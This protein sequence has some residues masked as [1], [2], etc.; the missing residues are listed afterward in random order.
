M[1]ALTGDTTG[2]CYTWSGDKKIY[3]SDLFSAAV[4]IFSTE[5]CYRYDSRDS[6]TLV[7]NSPDD[8]KDGSLSYLPCG[9]L[10]INHNIQ[11]NGE[12]HY[13]LSGT[14][15]KPEIWSPPAGMD[16]PFDKPHGLK[17]PF[18]I[19]SIVCTG[20]VYTW[21]YDHICVL[22]VDNFPYTQIHYYGNKE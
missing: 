19:H 7:F 5:W 3:E 4:N 6:Y 22:D 2:T 1:S 11:D 21:Y 16:G 14:Y 20:H 12:D 10:S 9:S 13:S 15:T 17:Y 8:N 18:Y